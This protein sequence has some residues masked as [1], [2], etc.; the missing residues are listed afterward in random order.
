[1]A[2]QEVYKA[3]FAA[4]LQE[5]Y[6]ESKFTSARVQF[7]WYRIK[8]YPNEILGRCAE[9]VKVRYEKFPDLDKIVSVCHEIFVE[10]Q[11]HERKSHT[12]I[13]ECACS[14]SGVRCV[15]GYAFQCPCPSGKIN[16]PTL[17]M[18][19]GEK[20]Y[21]E[22]RQ[23]YAETVV[24]ETR[25]NLFCYDKLTGKTSFRIKPRPFKGSAVDVKDFTEPARRKGDN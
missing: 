19:A 24:T 17:P 14:G 6:G 5:K 15:D 3:E 11:K 8:L 12:P 22:G 2:T 21:I 9:E 16:Y 4:P 1:M 18:Y 20:P 23:E 25:A 13:K 7:I 10:H